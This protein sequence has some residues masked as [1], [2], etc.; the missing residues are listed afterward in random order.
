MS[1]DHSSVGSRADARTPSPSV[2]SG[3]APIPEWLDLSGL[4]DCRRAALISARVYRDSYFREGFGFDHRMWL[5]MLEQA[6]EYRAAERQRLAQS[7]R[8]AA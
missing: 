6:R 1:R 2:A 8:K 4:R 5:S 3:P 7:H